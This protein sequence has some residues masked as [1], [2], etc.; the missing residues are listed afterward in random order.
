MSSPSISRS[1]YRSLYLRFSSQSLACIPLLSHACRMP[2]PS[3]PPQLDD[4]NCMSQA[5]HVI[6][7]LIAQVSPVSNYSN[8]LGSKYSQQPVMLHNANISIFNI[9]RRK[10]Q[11]II[12]FLNKLLKMNRT[13]RS[14]QIV[15]KFHVRN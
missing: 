6:K 14:C 3:H 10:L 2:Y 11:E 4:S 9:L 1:S 13:G 7:L 8:V 15:D 5:V 12:R